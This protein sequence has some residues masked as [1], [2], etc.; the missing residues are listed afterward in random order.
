MIGQIAKLQVRRFGMNWRKSEIKD[1]LRSG[2]M[3]GFAGIRRRSGAPPRLD[4]YVL[5][6]TMAD[7]GEILSIAVH[8]QTRRRGVAGALLTRT[9]IFM[10]NKHVKRVFLEV[11]GANRAAITFYTKSGFRII[12]IRRNYYRSYFGH[13][14]NALLFC[15]TFSSSRIDRRIQGNSSRRRADRHIIQP[16]RI[17]HK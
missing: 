6:R 3:T 15:G 16:H 8:G 2:A 5:F 12:D 9:L 1:M 4:G 7:E 13:P 10:D 17:S 14:H 11:S